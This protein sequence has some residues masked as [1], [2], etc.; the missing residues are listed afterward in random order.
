[1]DT[2][3]LRDLFRDEMS[4][5]EEPFLWSDDLVYGY[6]DDAQRMFCRLTEGIGDASSAST[7]LAVTPGRV[8]VELDELILN[9][10]SAARADDGRAIEV[11]N[12]EDMATRGWRFDGRTGP[13][14]ALVIGEEAHR[15]RTYPLSSETMTIAL[16]VF[17][18]PTD[19]ITGENDEL[20]ID[21]QHHRHLLLWM[22]ALAYGKQDAE[23]FDKTKRLEFDQAFRAYCG[24]AKLEQERARHKTRVVA[25]GGIPMGTRSSSCY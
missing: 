18:L 3:E 19:P 22:K 17:R 16:S 20:E 25:Y 23:T 15:A 10:R 8:W 2:G 24:A 9:I 13:V 4:D 5:L 1:M 6:T 7:L 14:R 11:L 21:E 12:R